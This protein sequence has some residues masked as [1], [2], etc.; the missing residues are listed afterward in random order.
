MT[1]TRRL[2]T[3]AVTTV[4]FTACR[5]EASE[6]AK[7]QDGE[8]S[9]EA[10]S[11]RIS[12]E[13]HS[14]H[15]GYVYTLGNQAE[16]N[17]VIVYRRDED[18]KLNFLRSVSTN[19]KGTGIG[20][21][22]QGAISLSDNR[23]ILLAVNAGSNTISSFRVS[24]GD[25]DLVSTV[26]SQG[27]KPISITQH[28]GL[29]YVL[30]AGGTGNIS[31]F[32]IIGN[33]K[34]IPIPHSE[35]PLSTASSDPAQ[36]SF[37]N[38]GRTLVVTEKG[39]NKIISYTLNFFGVP[40]E[41]HSLNSAN[42]TP[43]GFAVGEDGKIFVSEAAGG[44]PGASSVSSYKV[45][46]DGAISLINGPVLAG[47]TAA[48]WV[49]VTD[50]NKFVYA[51]NTGS[52]DVSS[53]TASASGNLDIFHAVAGNTG[54]TPIDAALSDQS[55]F[56]YALNAGDVSISA[57]RVNNNGELTT[58]QTVPGLQTGTIGLAAE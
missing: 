11:E 17:K 5:K 29:V 28:N 15:G 25:L 24:N 2:V 36:I 51:S 23:N 4:L 37:V 21:G 16:E 20:L 56:L 45:S 12:Q 31:G 26:S 22:S 44:A 39:T 58:I 3:I 18:G 34:L 27:L 38:E 47:Q 53:F 6:P 52:N 9:I 49:V 43:F 48:C 57:F 35:R 19:G 55:Q 42:A 14:S 54:K 50:N 32:R 40:A 13:K 41:F 46:Y 33:G 8:I 10:S 7:Q 30:N 1:K